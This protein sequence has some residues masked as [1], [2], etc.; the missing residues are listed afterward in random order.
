MTALLVRLSAVAL[1]ALSATPG[2]QGQ[3]QRRQ[4]IA[5]VAPASP[6]F[7][8]GGG[9]PRGALI[10][11]E[12]PEAPPGY[13]ATELHMQ[14]SNGELPLWRLRAPLLEARQSPALAE[15]GGKLY[16]LGGSRGGI[17][18]ASLSEYDPLTDAWTPRAS[19][20]SARTEAAAVS[21]EGRVFAI[22]GSTPIVDAYDPQTDT[23]GRRDDLDTTRSGLAAVAV[24]GRIYAFGGREGTQVLSS[25]ESYDPL[26]D[27][28]TPRAPMP[29][30]R[31]FL[32]AAVVNGRIYA[33]GGL[34]S[35]QQPLSV[36]E[37]YDPASNAWRTVAPCP[38][39]S[40][41][42][43]ASGA[44]GRLYLLG[45]ESQGG[46]TGQATA[47]SYAPLL[48]EWRSEPGLLAPRSRLATAALG[49][50]LI[51]VGGYQDTG[52]RAVDTVMEF[53]TGLRTLFAHRKN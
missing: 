28:W 34:S 18:L 5:P 48:D 17:P 19:M 31:E 45:G 12:T 13:S 25:V 49:E 37:E 4:P 16:V 29:T 9:V 2:Q 22:G 43:G 10:F 20:P 35:V 7:Q 47:Y 42:A 36:V 32:S 44:V 50:R 33:V 8:L 40:V 30:A 27:L 51:A 38:F 46:P 21:I 26:M 52:L 39:P 53:E 15:L 14:V 23:W 1:A 11:S 3:V 41:R 6:A 24:G